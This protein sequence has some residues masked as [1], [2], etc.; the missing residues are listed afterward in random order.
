MQVCTVHRPPYQYR[1][2]A[3]RTSAATCAAVICS[4]LLADEQ[5]RKHARTQSHTRST[6]RASTR[7]SFLA[8]M[9]SAQNPG[10]CRPGQPHGR[11][12]PRTGYNSVAFGVYGVGVVITPL[13]VPMLQIWAEAWPKA[14]PTRRSRHSPADLDGGRKQERPP[15]SRS[16]P[17]TLPALMFSI[18]GGPEYLPSTPEVGEATPSR[19]AGSYEHSHG[20][21]HRPS[22]PRRHC[23]ARTRGQALR[24][25]LSTGLG[26]CIRGT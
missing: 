12:R 21:K 11:I 15:L 25:V 6:L 7:V 8:Q 23:V 22:S 4:V 24:R 26:P 9:P 1:S 2:P 3:T 13:R 10:H 16:Q 19:P 5:T 14:V 18:V 20:P 17:R